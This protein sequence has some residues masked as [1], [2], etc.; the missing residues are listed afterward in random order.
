M[1]NEE[2]KIKLTSDISTSSTK[3]IDMLTQVFDKE[4]KERSDYLD[5]ILRERPWAE[6]GI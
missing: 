3:L 6:E 1:N 4:D 2:Q 5:K